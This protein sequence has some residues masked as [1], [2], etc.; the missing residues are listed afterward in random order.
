MQAHPV[1]Q[2]ITGFEFKLIGFLT[3]R[4]FAY[5][6]IAGVLSFVFFALPVYPILRFVLILPT[7]LLGLALAFLPVNDIPF[8]RWIVAFIRS[9]YSPTKRVW[10]KE[11]VEIGFLAPGFSVYL[12]RQKLPARPASTDRTKLQR[13]LSSHQKLSRASSLDLEEQDRLS[14]LNQEVATIAFDKKQP[15][16]VAEV[17]PQESIVA[18]NPLSPENEPKN[19]GV[20]NG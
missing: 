2:N 19:L 20:H 5:L 15:E 17:V 13:Y 6:A 11:P 16:L 12:Q 10:R 14:H 3:I 1:P 9:V 8:D 18:G 7:A 4:Q